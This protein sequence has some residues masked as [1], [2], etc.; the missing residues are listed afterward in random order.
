MLYE[1]YDGYGFR[2]AVVE[3][4]SVE[5]AYEKAEALGFPANTSHVE[6]VDTERQG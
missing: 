3:A 2:A 1:V 6:P 4:S 5:E